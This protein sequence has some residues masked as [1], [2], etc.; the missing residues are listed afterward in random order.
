MA[1]PVHLCCHANPAA[2]RRTH[3]KKL[4]SIITAIVVGSSSAAMA[5]PATFS[6]S[7]NGTFSASAGGLVRDH[8]T[9]ITSTPVRPSFSAVRPAPATIFERGPRPMVG[10]YDYVDW[11][12]LG[13]RA[14]NAKSY[15]QLPRDSRAR[16][17][18]VEPT[19]GAPSLSKV[20]VR[21]HN[22]TQHELD[23]SS[24]R[25]GAQGLMLPLAVMSSSVH[26]II[27]YPAAGSQGEFKASVA[28]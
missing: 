2:T 16:W 10:S 17:L 1:P 3:M 9:A 25:I 15:V 26:Q 13:T 5:A 11:M 27:F 12:W 23:V 19:R 22:G 6:A 14:A 8:R 7:V 4:M 20:F 24:M 18:L 21:Y 28:L